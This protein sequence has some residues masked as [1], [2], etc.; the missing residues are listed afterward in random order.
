MC[1]PGL[2]CARAHLT[3]GTSPAGTVRLSPG[4]FTTLADIE[5][6]ISAIASLA[7]AERMAEYAVILVQTTSHAVYA[8]RVLKQAGLAAL[9][10]T[11]RHL[12]SDCGSAVRIPADQR[13]AASEALS[14]AGVEFDRIELL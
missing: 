7:A 12:S 6:A 11:P 13:A 8:E 9:D 1:R 10:P 4:P 2:H 3:M 14:A 5:Q